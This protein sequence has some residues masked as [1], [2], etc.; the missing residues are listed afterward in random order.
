[1]EL[2]IPIAEK[3]VASLNEFLEADPIAIS[4]MMLKRVPCNQD[5]ADHPTVQVGQDL[6]TNW[7]VSI[8]GLLNGIC[9]RKG[10]GRGLIVMHT[11]RDVR[12]IPKRRVIKFT[13]DVNQDRFSP[14]E[15]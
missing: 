12:L 4:K 7:D 9:G 6:K 2:D 8:L 15:D 13:V 11:E 5:L 1:M 14:S 3:I 10:N